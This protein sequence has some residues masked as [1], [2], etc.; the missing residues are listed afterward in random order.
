MSK[1]AHND[2]PE[3]QRLSR[4]AHEAYQAMTS[5][6]APFDQNAPDDEFR[7]ALKLRARLAN[8]MLL[9]LTPALSRVQRSQL[10]ARW[11]YSNLY[12]YARVE[13]AM[14]R[15]QV[16]ERIR[17][18]EFLAEYEPEVAESGELPNGS[19]PLGVLKTLAN[20]K[21][22]GLLDDEKLEEI[23][24]QLKDPTISG[25]VKEE[26]GQEAVRE[27]PPK[28]QSKRE[29]LRHA[30]AMYEKANHIVSHD[31]AVPR[32]IVNDLLRATAAFA[33]LMATLDRK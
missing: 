15:A 16:D 32:K 12:T 8:D 13:L 23:T 14:G 33:D 2:A 31:D 26:L 5:Q 11:G 27:P 25:E 30:N 29:L 21:A 3:S 17:T 7:Q 22:K 19:I 4:S 6:L 1:D 24:P 9:W 20:A 10:F 18:F 28:R